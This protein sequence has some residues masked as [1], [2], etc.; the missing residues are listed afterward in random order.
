MRQRYKVLVAAVVTMLLGVLSLGT[1]TLTQASDFRSG[2]N[3]S[4]GKNETI[5]SSVYATGSAVTIAGTINGD[6]YCA[7]QTVTID[8]TVNGDVLCAG[9]TVTVNG[10]VNGDVRLAG[11]SIVLQNTTTDN[12]TLVGATIT[13]GDKAVIGKD[14]TV[15]GDVVDVRG[16]VN[17]DFV[18]GARSVTLG[19]TIDRN[20]TASIDEVA[21]GKNA[22]V[23]GNLNYQSERE[24][25]IDNGVVAGKTV[26]TQQTG[27][28]ETTPTMS[29]WLL[30]LAML[31]AGLVLTTVLASLVAPRALR[32]A[33]DLSVAKVFVSLLIGLGV[34]V[35]LPFVA[36]LLM[37]SL[38]GLWAGVIVL[39]LWAALL[40]LSPAVAS[41]WLGRV[42]LAG[43]EGKHAVLIA[44]IGGAS[45]ALLIWVP[46]VGSFIAFVALLLGS[47]AT[48]YGI[49]SS[50]QAKPTPAVETKKSTAKSPTKRKK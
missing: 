29:D 47:G 14:M 1:V 18:A 31:V 9:V 49:F 48:V 27:S 5:N 16:T 11:Q 22:S 17:R 8:A 3:V 4:T 26:F 6:V 39:I 28:S 45:V 42:L 19:G 25:T 20:V 33:T 10:K 36:V 2:T 46:F 50:Q 30:G 24:L 38:I 41:F 35:V 7:G 34:L 32:S 13:L 44:L 37:V 21:F 40:A 43:G 15:A 23:K 12:A